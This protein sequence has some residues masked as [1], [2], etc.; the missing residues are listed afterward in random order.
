[1]SGKSLSISRRLQCPMTDRALTSHRSGQ[2]TVL[3]SIPGR[4]PMHKAQHPYLSTVCRKH[5]AQHVGLNAPERHVHLHYGI[6]L[7]PRA[8]S[9]LLEGLRRQHGGVPGCKSQ[10]PQLRAQRA[11]QARTIGQP[12]RLLECAA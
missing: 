12:T 7:L 2:H 1:M 5:W 6:V 4:T 10:G 8:S 9:E 3:C 11:G